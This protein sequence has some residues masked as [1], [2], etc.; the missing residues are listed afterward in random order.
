MGERNQKNEQTSKAT[1]EREVERVQLNDAYNVYDGNV[2]R[3]RGMRQMHRDEGE[4][5]R[6]WTRG[7]G[8]RRNRHSERSSN[9]PPKCKLSISPR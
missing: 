2:E 6:G 3:P 7:G 9:S 8:R 1:E 5:R 4:E